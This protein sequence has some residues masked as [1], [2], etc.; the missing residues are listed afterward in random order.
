[1]FQAQL[2]WNKNCAF[3]FLPKAGPR[4]NVQIFSGTAICRV[5]ERSKHNT[6]MPKSDHHFKPQA[7]RWPHQALH[8]PTNVRQQ[9]YFVPVQGIIFVSFS[10]TLTSARYF[11]TLF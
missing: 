3:S 10:K 8:K 2:N 1:M 11:K 5:P 6:A 9:M 4:A 7:Q